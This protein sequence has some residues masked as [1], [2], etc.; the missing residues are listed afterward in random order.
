MYA[1][2][3]HLLFFGDKTTLNYAGKEVIQE[4]LADASHFELS[5]RAFFQ[6]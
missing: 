3:K 1:G 2:V 5:A 4:T 6:Y